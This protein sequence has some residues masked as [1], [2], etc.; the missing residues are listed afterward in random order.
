MGWQSHSLDGCSNAVLLVMEIVLWI[1]EWGPENPR[2]GLVVV[3]Y[4]VLANRMRMQTTWELPSQILVYINRVTAR[5]ANDYQ[6][7]PH[8]IPNYNHR[9]KDHFRMALLPLINHRW[10]IQV[11]MGPSLDQ[12]HM[13]VLNIWT[14]SLILPQAT[15][16]K[17]RLPEISTWLLHENCLTSCP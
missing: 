8:C 6:W 9:S 11:V 15:Y 4:W 14:A 10:I 7:W 13:K 17:W 16:Y 5:L 3:E 2:T 12:W 1:W